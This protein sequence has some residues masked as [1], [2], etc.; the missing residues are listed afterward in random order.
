MD[1]GAIPVPRRGKIMSEI[2]R[3]ATGIR[4]GVYW[5]HPE[6]G[7]I[8]IEILRQD[9]TKVWTETRRALCVIPRENPTAFWR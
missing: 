8:E 9:G 6:L 2:P 7:R 3:R 1:N 4:P 5:T